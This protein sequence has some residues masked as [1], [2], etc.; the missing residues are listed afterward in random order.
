MDDFSD[1]AVQRTSQILTTEHFTLQG[2]RNATIT[3]A[4]GRLGHYISAVGSS[5]VALAF[6]ANVSGLGLVFFAFSLVVFPIMIIL[7][8]VT[9][10]RTIQ[11]G[12]D[13]TRLTQAINRIRHYYVEAAP[14]AE[15]Y[16]SFPHFDDPESVQQTMMPFHSLLQGL[17]STPGPIILINSVLSGAFA[18]ILAV[19]IFSLAFVPAIIV[20]LVAL[21]IAFAVHMLYSRRL[22]KQSARQGLDVRFPSSES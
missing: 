14:E 6:V 7:G 12:S 21:V 15:P 1:Q 8:I 4:N 9:L 13:F 3:E 10:I 5:V 20:A 19:A 22:W 11:I 18:G 17:A 16:L 2:A